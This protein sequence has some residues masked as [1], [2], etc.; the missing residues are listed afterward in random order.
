MDLSKSS[1]YTYWGTR[2]DSKPIYY[3]KNT[4]SGGSLFGISERGQNL[5][6]NLAMGERHRVS[7]VYHTHPG[8]TML[9]LDDPFQ[10][11]PGVKVKAVGWDGRSRG[12]YYDGYEFDEIVVIGKRKN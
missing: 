12:S 10:T 11:T 2:A 1:G 9:S 5:Y 6:L 7:G 3:G 4:I 8:N